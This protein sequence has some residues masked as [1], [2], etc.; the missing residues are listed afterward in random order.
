[1]EPLRRVGHHAQIMAS[2]SPDSASSRGVNN[3]S[4]PCSD[5]F[6][7]KATHYEGGEHA[8]VIAPAM[9]V[10]RR[11]YD[12]FATFLAG[13]GKSVVTFDY[14]GIADSKPPSL[15]RFNGSL[16]DW[17]RLDLAAVID[18]TSRAL[19]PRRI[20]LVAHSAG[21]QIVG[22]AANA[23]LLDRVVIVTAGSGYWKHWSGLRRIGIRL[24]WQVMPPVARTLGFFP[25]RALRLG[26]HDLPREVAVDWATWGRHPEYL[27]G[28]HDNEPYRALRVP[29]LVWSAEGDHYAPRPAVEA[30][31]KHYE[32]ASIEHRRIED[33]LVRHWGFFRKAT[34][35]T[36]WRETLEWLEKA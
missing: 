16:T 26:N 22:L 6:V 4:I 19:K 7:L 5:G 23:G 2:C 14:R 18:W 15:R 25:S 11:Y 31:I 1:M 13:N 28:F 35:E 30:L 34:G 12:A 33:L 27:F 8:I 21:G 36:F 10:A 20:S 17:G 3:K 32:N 24:L 9:G 29:M